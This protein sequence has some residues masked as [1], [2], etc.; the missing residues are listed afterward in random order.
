MLT[1]HFVAQ[2][3]DQN[4]AGCTVRCVKRRESLGH[5]ELDVGHRLFAADADA[6]AA[7]T[8]YCSG[9]ADLASILRHAF[10]RVATLVVGHGAWENPHGEF[11]CR[12]AAHLLATRRQPLSGPS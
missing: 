3:P 4:L 1:S 6:D 7:L 10:S 12:I 5:F 9:R 11:A 2:H 8:R